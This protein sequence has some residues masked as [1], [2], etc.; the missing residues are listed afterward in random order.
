MLL[1]N[2]ERSG[3]QKMPTSLPPPPPHLAPQQ[4]HPWSQHPI[5]GVKV[6][7]RSWSI[8][9]NFNNSTS[10]RSLTEFKKWRGRRTT[11]PTTHH[12]GKQIVG[13]PSKEPTKNQRFGREITGFF[14]KNLGL[15]KYSAMNLEEIIQ[16]GG[17]PIFFTSR[18]LLEEMIPTGLRITK[19]DYP[20]T[21][22]GF[23]GFGGY[24]FENDVGIRGPFPVQF[25]T[26]RIIPMNKSVNNHGDRFRPLGQHSLN[27]TGRYLWLVNR[28]PIR[29][30]L[31][32]VDPSDGSP[33][34]KTVIRNGFSGEA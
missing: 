1:V 15:V 2:P 7:C 16:G 21:G 29:S 12:S 11:R 9:R 8:M 26:W 14:R 33:S 6:S 34:S 22:F 31:T 4:R 23:Y 3:F 27:P 25:S 30:P 10:K 20:L 5:P 24:G 17:F 18:K 32:Y 19:I 28:G 13:P